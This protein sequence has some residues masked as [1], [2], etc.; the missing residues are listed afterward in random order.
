MRHAGFIRQIL[1]KGSLLTDEPG[2]PGQCR[3]APAAVSFDNPPRGAGQH[4]PPLV[5]RSNGARRLM[6]QSLALGG[7]LLA[8][9]LLLEEP[10]GTVSKMLAQRRPSEVW[11]FRSLEFSRLLAAFVASLLIH[12]VIYGTYKGGQALGWWERLHWKPMGR[13]IEQLQQAK[14]AMNDPKHQPPLMFVDVSPAAASK[15]APKD[16]PYYS[17]RNSQASNPLTDE[18]TDQPMVDGSQQEM[19]RTEDVPPLKAVPLQPA[20]SPPAPEPPPAPKKEKVQRLEAPEGDLLL[21]KAEEPQ[22]PEKPSPPDT[23]PRPR[24]LKE[25]LARLPEGQV[26]QLAGRKMKQEGGVRRL[27]VLSTLDVKASP[28]GDYD[29][30]II[31]AIQNRWFDLLDMRGFGHEKSGKVV[32]EFRLHYDGRISDMSVEENTVDEMLSLLCQKAVMDPAPYAHWPSDMRRMV[33]ASYRDVRFTF[34]YN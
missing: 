34:Y 13:V 31:I 22:K 25:A 14:T 17:D 10:C 23:K 16:S 4:L 2:V 29:R 9:L 33:G 19:V 6:L 12:L 1:E 21:A 7:T 30:A 18:I 11:V 27:S 24:T 8:K 5:E 3:D 28:F 26:P 32:L 15:K 20:A